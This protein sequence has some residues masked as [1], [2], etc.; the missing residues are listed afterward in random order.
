MLRFAQPAMDRLRKNLTSSLHAAVG[1]KKHRLQTLGGSADVVDESM[2]NIAFNAVMAGEGN[3]GDS[4]GAVTDV[5]FLLCPSSRML[6]LD[7]ITF[8]R[9]EQYRAGDVPELSTDA[10]I[11]LAKFFVLEWSTKFDYHMFHDLPPQL[12]ME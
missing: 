9:Q 4:V 10:I 1:A 6:A 5:A 2:A 11:A 7:E 8:W 12:M 3:S